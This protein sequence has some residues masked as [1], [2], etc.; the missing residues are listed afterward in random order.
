LDTP[1]LYLNKPNIARRQLNAAIR[2]FLRGEDI[3]AVHTVAAASYAILRDL[4]DD[5][6]RDELGDITSQMIFGYAQ[7]YLDGEISELPEEVKANDQFMAVFE[8]FCETIRQNPNATAHEVVH[9]T[10][11]NNAR[12]EHWGKFNETA[13]VLK[14]AERD[15]G[16][17]HKHD[18]QETLYLLLR[19]Y[20]SYHDLMHDMDPE[21]NVLALYNA[22][23]SGY[24]GGLADG[25]KAIVQDLIGE[26]E[27]QIRAAF[28][29]F[30]EAMKDNDAH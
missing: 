1:E 9:G 17:L 3:L 30:L 28:L 2:M 18:P 11:S 10:A 27:S 8:I 26:N 12:R 15:P 7:R 21:M 14:H 20:G 25:Y 5:R 22:A 19:A 29:S 23:V 16:G 6:G 24:T 13:N 4:K